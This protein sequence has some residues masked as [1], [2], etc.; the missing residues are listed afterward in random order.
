MAAGLFPTLIGHLAFGAGL[1]IV[2][3]ILEARHNPWWVPRSRM[4]AARVAR[5]KE[6]V[7]TSAPALWT[8]VVAIAL[9]LPIIL[10][11]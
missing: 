7:L 4:E 11:M 5:R 8:L 10:G 3:H 2:F 6:Q 9:T 1:G